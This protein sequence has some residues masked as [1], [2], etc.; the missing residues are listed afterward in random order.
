MEISSL[1]PFGWASGRENVHRKLRFNYR[2]A[3]N[4]VIKH[5]LNLFNLSEHLGNFSSYFFLAYSWVWSVLLI[6][7]NVWA[8]K[9]ELRNLLIRHESMP[10]VFAQLHSSAQPSGGRQV[11]QS[12]NHQIVIKIETRFQLYIYSSLSRRRLR[13]TF[14]AL[15]R[16]RI[17]LSQLDQIRSDQGMCRR[18]YALDGWKV[19]SSRPLKSSFNVALYLCIL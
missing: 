11:I 9:C 5:A 2:S 13:D 4:Y 16:A 1:K 14:D 18:V 7:S 19:S 8:F 12:S 3:K 6:C 17:V 15:G 10:S